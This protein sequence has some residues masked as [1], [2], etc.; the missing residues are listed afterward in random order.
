MGGDM[1]KQD[2]MVNEEDV[3]AR[4]LE[5]GETQPPRADVQGQSGGPQSDQVV[6]ETEKGARNQE[7]EGKNPQ[8]NPPDRWSR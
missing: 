6:G 5:Y 3:Q 8:G 7:A 1:S 4:K 2:E